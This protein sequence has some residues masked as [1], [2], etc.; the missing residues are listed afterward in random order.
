LLNRDERYPDSDDRNRERRIEY[1][2][3][4]Q[5]GATEHHH[6]GYR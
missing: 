1:I 4:H 6:N 5:G 2:R 3:E